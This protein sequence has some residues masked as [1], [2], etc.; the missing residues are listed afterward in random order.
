MS[1]KSVC[2]CIRFC[3]CN[4]CACVCVCYRNACTYVCRV[5]HLCV[6]LCALHGHQFVCVLY[7][8]VCLLFCVICMHV[9]VLYVL[10]MVVG[11]SVCV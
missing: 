4:V 11:V 1:V 3:V 9:C 10:R 7:A 6:F 2:L 8:K 5:F